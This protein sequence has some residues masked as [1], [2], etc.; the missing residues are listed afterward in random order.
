M[1]DILIQ[2]FFSTFLS[3]SKIFI[4][5]LAAGILVRKNILSEN[6]LHGLSVATVDV[7]LPCLSFT[8]ILTKFRPGEF[9]IWW[10]LPAAGILITAAGMLLGWLF[11]LREMPDKRN[12]VPIA[13]V[14][15][16]AFLVLPLGAILFPDQFER[17]SVYV[18]M[19]VMGQSLPIWSLAKQL[20]TS[21][22]GTR[23]RFSD[24]VT[25]PL[26][27]TLTA[28]TLVFTGMHQLFFTSQ[29]P[30]SAGLLNTAI[31]AVFDAAKL[32]GQA[33]VPLA[34]FILGGVLGGIAFKLRPYLLD[35]VRVISIKFI[36]LPLFTIMIVYFSGIGESAPL[37][38]VFFV[39][40]SSSAPA[41]ALVLQVKKYGGDEQKI[42]SIVLVSYLTCLVMMPVWV[43]VWN[44][45]SQ[46]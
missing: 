13:G 12:M 7:F 23:M 4:I 40:E 34:I 1:S 16:A 41:I 39:I 37:L 21:V 9:E 29:A 27:A 42:G 26:V 2:A 46:F 45:I 8:S 30:D 38:A 25:P 35:A 17:F 33:T 18:F 44:L 36:L 15:N 32:L 20:N 11:F 3:M 14:Q 10:V 31:A 5:I 24:M 22:P 28:I 6:N 19:F 43:A